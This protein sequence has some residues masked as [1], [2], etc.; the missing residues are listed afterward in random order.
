MAA[1]VL[2]RVGRDV[3]ADPLVEFVHRLE[4]RLEREALGGV[5]G[6]L[7]VLAIL[8]ADPFAVGIVDDLD[9]VGVHQRDVARLERRLGQHVVFAP[10]GIPAESL[11]PHV[12]AG[13]LAIDGELGPVPG[14]GGDA[15]G[16]GLVLHDVDLAVALDDRVQLARQHPRAGR[17]VG[18]RVDHRNLVVLLDGQDREHVGAVPLAVAFEHGHRGGDGVGVALLAMRLDRG[19]RLD[20]GNL[21]TTEV[22][23][24]PRLQ[25]LVNEVAKPEGLRVVQRTAAD[26]VLEE[27]ALVAGAEAVAAA[28]GEELKG[29]PILAFSAKICSIVSAP[30][31][32]SRMRWAL[33]GRG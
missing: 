9:A 14:I 3:G 16:R 19:H 20:R 29:H 17:A 18:V 15:V 6:L 22:V 10:V 23:Q 21:G 26:L 28:V 30:P 13:H 32:I 31:A 4:A 1:V 27:V 11:A 24:V 2:V 5:A 7:P 12:V 25:A 8:G 33:S